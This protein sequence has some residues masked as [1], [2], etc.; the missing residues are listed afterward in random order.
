[1]HSWKARLALCLAAAA[2][3]TTA[4]ASIG[5]ARAEVESILSCDSTKPCLQWN[6]SGSGDSIKGVS[7][8][9]VALEGQT[10]FNSNGKTAGKSGVL[11][12]DVSTTGTLNSG[13]NGSSINGTGVTGTET[14]SAGQNGVAGFSASTFGSGVYGQNSSTG[15]GVA[16]SNTATSRSSGASGLLANGGTANDGIHSF[17]GSGN[18]LYAFSQSGTPLFANQGA[19]TTAPELYLQDTSSSKNDII[20]AV[21]PSGDVFDVLSSGAVVASGGLTASGFAQFRDGAEIVGTLDLP[22]SNGNEFDNAPGNFNPTLTIDGGG[23]NQGD[24]VLAVRDNSGQTAMDVTDTGDVG[25]SGLLF[26]QGPCGTGCIVGNKR[27]RAVT[28][29]APTE[30]EPTIEDN[31]EGTLVGGSDYIALDPKFAN[32]IDTN[33]TYLVS[34][35]P[36]GDCRGLYVAQRSARGFAVREL[37][38][39]SASVGFEYRIVAKRFGVHAQRLPMT[40]LPLAVKP[41][42]RH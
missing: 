38:G 8:S 16:G 34:V 4:I 31:G 26:T 12:A 30:S 18:A 2:A 1:M 14:G 37:Q 40:T 24:T 33:A 25:I 23:V 10:K 6:N 39:G 21:G 42:R 28:E 22:S 15:A 5:P 3:V 35:T 17:A 20:E 29:Y 32:V 19:N 27:V 7:T 11:G 9:G 13:V 36:E 41:R